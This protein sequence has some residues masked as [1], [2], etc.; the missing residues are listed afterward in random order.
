VK[1]LRRVAL[2][3][4]IV[5]VLGAALWMSLQLPYRNFAAETFVKFERG[6]GTI[7]M[8]RAL[9]Q[10]GVIRY[11]WLFWIE[12]ALHPSTKLTAGEYK[13]QDAASVSAI[14]G[15]IAHGDVYYFE[16][17]VPEGS[18]I[19]DIARLVEAAGTMPAQDFLTAAENP[20][21]I[22]DLDPKAE[23][24]EGYLFPATYRL[25]HSTTAAEL[26]QLMT[27]QFRRQ[28]KKLL[29][30][31]TIV[32][33]ADP[34]RTVTMASMVEKETPVPEERLLIAGVFVNRLKLGMRLECDPTTIYAALLDHRYRGTIHRSDLENKN[35]YNTYRNAGLPPGPIANPGMEALAAALHPAITNYL[36]FVAKPSGGGHQFS[37]TLAEH[38]NAVRAYRHGTQSQAKKSPAKAPK[39]A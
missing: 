8:A 2:L 38:D 17:T 12:R 13:F 9:E 23:T 6:S 10:E 39:K 26:C 24:L 28:W 25:S 20:M 32:A 15:R 34:H 30:G 33:S 3:L 19:F 5:L 1:R 29:A 36:Y 35:P 21:S 22:R 11:A 18:N 4:L 16:F 14:F 27:A 37:T 31:Q 7:A